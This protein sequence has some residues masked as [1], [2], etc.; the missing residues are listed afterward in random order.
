MHDTCNISVDGTDSVSMNRNLLTQNGSRT[1][2]KGQDYVKKSAI[3]LDE[4]HI[5]LVHGPY[6]CEQLTDLSIFR[7]GIKGHLIEGERVV[8]DKVYLDEKCVTPYNV[9]EDQSYF[10]SLARAQHETCNRRFK[11]F[12]L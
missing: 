6:S 2:L 3:S 5:V 7:L 10:H 9:G 4:G 12:F 8:A 1:N 11:Q